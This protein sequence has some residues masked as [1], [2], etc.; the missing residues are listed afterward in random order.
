[1]ALDIYST[2]ACSDDLK[3]VSSEGGALLVPRRRQ[4]SGDPVQQI[5]CLR[6][7][8]RSG[9]MTLDGAMFEQVVR[10]ADGAPISDQLPIPSNTQ[11]S[12]DKEL[13]HEHE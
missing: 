7:W 2:P 9:L 12:D 8:R 4:L 13:Y 3:R 10:R 11:E 6:S 5:L 1:M